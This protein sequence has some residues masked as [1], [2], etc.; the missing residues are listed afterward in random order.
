MQFTGLK[1]RSETVLI[2]PKK[3]IPG[4]LISCCKT[5]VD[6]VL[7]FFFLITF[8]SYKCSCMRMIFYVNYGSTDRTNIC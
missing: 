5:C 7:F 3:E 8:F 2:R 1:L 4:F 6:R